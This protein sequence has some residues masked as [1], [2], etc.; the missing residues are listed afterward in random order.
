MSNKKL[1]VWLPLILAGMI[2]AGMYIGYELHSNPGKGFFNTSKSNALQET[3]DLIRLRYVDSVHL[4]SLEGEAIEQMVNQLDPHSVYIPAVSLKEANED[5]AGNFEGI[6]VEFNVF[7]D[8]VNVLYVIEGGPSEKAGLQIGDKILKVNNAILTYKNLDSDDVKK[9]IRG[10]RGTTI[11]LE[12]LRN[13]KIMIVPVTRGTI[14][15]SSIDAAYMID[16]S[17]GYIRLNKFSESSYEEFMQSLE[18]L[19]KEGLQKLIL[20]I[21]SN[22]GGFMNEAVDIAD[23]FLDNDKLI[24]YT[25]GTN[26]PRREYRSKRNGLFET[27]K[28]VVLV[29]ELSAS[30]SEVLAGALQDWERATI[31]GR[32]TF[33]KGLVQEQYTLS[34]GS[35]IRLTVARYY[36]PSGRS[37]QRSYEKGRKVYMDD[38]WERF[39]SGELIHVDSTKIINGNVYETLGKEKRKVYG[40]GGIMPDIFVPFDTTTYQRN[41]NRLFANGT[42]NRFVYQYYLRNKSSLSQY[43]SATDYAVRFNKDNELWQRLKEYIPKDSIDLGKVSQDDKESLQKRLKALLARFRWRND[44]FYHVLN[45][46]DAVVLKA[47]EILAK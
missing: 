29:D 26:N 23:E 8:T 16:R 13:N 20:D 21:R 33:G 38:L 17:I 4:D 43:S 46:E 27:G 37:I 7:S 25:S 42:F 35:A 45:T 5:L 40:G 41:I 39:S 12:I 44:G 24:V 14:P 2:I 18:R 6:G 19:Q 1:Q 15:V 32:R 34:D 28:L 47:I 10:K 31:I 36:T 9:I 3:V 30:A 11:D 22:G